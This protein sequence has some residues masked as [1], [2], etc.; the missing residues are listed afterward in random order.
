M[1]HCGMYLCILYVYIYIHIL[2]FYVCLLRLPIE[3]N[4][5]LSNPPQSCVK[6]DRIQSNL[7]NLHL[8]YVHVLVR[9]RLVK[10]TKKNDTF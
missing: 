7:A 3:S 9:V 8:Q 6:K 10:L 1:F 4:P 5:K 2:C